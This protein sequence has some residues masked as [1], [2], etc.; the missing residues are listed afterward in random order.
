VK[1][2]P[3]D[4]SYSRQ[5]LDVDGL[6]YAYV[7]EGAGP[8]VVLVHGNPS[9]SYY[10]R[11][12][13]AALPAAGYR[14]LA[15]DHIG[16]GRSAK[17]PRSRYAYTLATRVADF[18]RW[19]DA[20]CPTGPVTLVVHDWGG[21][22]ALAWAVEHPQRMG[23]LV[24]LNTAAFPLPAG[25]SLPLAL[26]AARLPLVGPAAVCYGNAFAV[27]A[28]LL[29]VRRRMP[30]AVR[31]GYLAPYDR[32]AHRVAVLDFVRDIPLRPSDPAFAILRRTETRLPTLTG[33][34]VL[35]CWGMRDFV[36]DEQILARWEKIFPAAQVHRFPEAGHY[37]L[38]DA[39][40]Q[41]V[42][43]V[44]RFLA[45]GRPTGPVVR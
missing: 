1:T 2:E 3:A 9:W 25:K 40:A 31:R 36:L 44:E 20:V 16:M 45:A 19:L 10:F 11:P 4:F 14:A 5:V 33:V 8:P 30:A 24:L 35:I 15:P 37:V 34:P 13:I 21:A 22:V 39:A 29:G 27:G 41:V 28:T 17:P 6:A 38:E 26:R 7:E 43:L 12:L 23:R 42:P 18:T 32:P